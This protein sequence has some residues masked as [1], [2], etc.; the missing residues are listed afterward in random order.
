MPKTDM[1]NDRPMDRPDCGDVGFR[2][3]RV[4]GAAFKDCGDNKRICG[5]AGSHWQCWPINFFLN[6]NRQFEKD[7]HM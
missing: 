1:E 2:R 3:A 5:C 4:A 7:F 6:F